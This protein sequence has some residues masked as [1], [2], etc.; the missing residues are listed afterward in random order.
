MHINHKYHLIERMYR[1]HFLWGVAVFSFFAWAWYEAGR[2]FQDWI[3]VTAIINT[4]IYPLSVFI[5]D[6]F[7]RVLLPSS[8]FSFIKNQP[9]GET[10]VM[11]IANL[12]CWF[13]SFILSPIAIIYLFC[14][15]KGQ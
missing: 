10:K 12:F 13:F 15:N 2:S 5:C 7:L 4:L 6:N 11:L 1:K 9:Q 14:R 3:F 8:F